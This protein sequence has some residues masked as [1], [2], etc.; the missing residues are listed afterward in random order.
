[1]KDKKLSPEKL[2]LRKIYMKKYYARKKI[3]RM[4][5]GEFV[6]I[7]RGKIKRN[8]T[9]TMRRGEFIVSFK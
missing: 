3:E 1:M 8:S 2:A 5:S 7:C 9:F 6:S 4:N